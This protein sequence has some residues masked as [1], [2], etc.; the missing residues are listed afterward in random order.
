MI[1][2]A[3]VIGIESAT[4]YTD[5]ERRVEIRVE[6]ADR[7]FN[8]LRIPERLLGMALGVDDELE[9]VIRRFDS[10]A[11]AEAAGQQRRGITTTL[12]DEAAKAAAPRGT[13]HES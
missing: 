9:V 13:R 4:V 12:L 7:M 2:K 8:R 10:F 11:Q 6:G 5:G 3:Q 1:L